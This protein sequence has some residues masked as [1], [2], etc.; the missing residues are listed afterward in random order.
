V[1]LGIYFKFILCSIQFIKVKYK[2]RK[3]IAETERHLYFY[4]T[5]FYFFPYF[6]VFISSSFFCFVVCP[7][8]TNPPVIFTVLELYRKKNSYT[9]LFGNVYT[10]VVYFI[11]FITNSKFYSFCFVMLFSLLSFLF[12]FSSCVPGHLLLH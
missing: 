3:V 11:P 6:C 2:S 4:F 9:R 5:L 10:I 7:H 8:Y 1:P 12:L